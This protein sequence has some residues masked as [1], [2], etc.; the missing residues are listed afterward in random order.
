MRK[1]HRRLLRSAIV[2]ALARTARLRPQRRRAARCPR[3][4]HRRAGRDH[5]CAEQ[6]RAVRRLVQSCDDH[7]RAVYSN[8]RYSYK[9]VRYIHMRKRGPAL[10]ISRSLWTNAR[11]SKGPGQ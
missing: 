4:Q 10:P 8:G 3:A 6:L 1:L 11:A 2:G 9:Y 5:R 7:R